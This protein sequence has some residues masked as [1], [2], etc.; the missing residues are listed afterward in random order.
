MPRFMLSTAGAAVSA[1]VVLVAAGCGGGDGAETATEATTAAASTERYCEVASQLDEAGS[2]AFAQLED[3]PDA[4]E[5][6]FQATAKR[7][8]E[9]HAAEIDELIAIAPEEISQA[10][11]TLVAAGRARA[12]LDAGD[13]PTAAEE[14]EA[15]QR[16]TQFEEENCGGA[17]GEEEK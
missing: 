1:A 6:D 7:F 13:A 4:T 14:R 11:D 5:E 8:Y 15:E 16:V 2:K 17:I 9:E 10:V 12:G 3:D